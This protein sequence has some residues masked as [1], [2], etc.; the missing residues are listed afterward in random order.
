MRYLAIFELILI[1]LGLVGFSLYLFIADN[2]QDINESSMTKSI[3]SGQL[4]NASLVVV[5]KYE[6]GGKKNYRYVILSSGKD[7]SDTTR[8]VSKSTYNKIKTGDQFFG[9]DFGSDYMVPAFDNPQTDDAWKL[10]TGVMSAF[11]AFAFIF[12]A[13]KIYSRGKIK[14]MMRFE[15]GYKLSGF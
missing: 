15:T 9:Y 4:K 8:L 6:T 11:F 1:S 14:D 3:R 5:D 13:C 12:A 7:Q 2:G 10:Y